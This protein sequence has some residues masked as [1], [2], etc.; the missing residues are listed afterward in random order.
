MKKNLLV[1]FGEYRTF[2]Y[3]IPQLDRLNEVDIIFSTWD[4]TQIISRSSFNSPL[5]IPNE[6]YNIK[7]HITE[8]DIKSI[9]SNCNPIIHKTKSSFYNE[10]RNLYKMHFHWIESLNAI[11]DNSKYDKLILHRS[12]MVSDWHTL[13]DRNFE[14][15]TIYIDTNRAQSN[16]ENY[17]N[18]NF[19][20]GDYSFAGNYDVM[21]KFINLFKNSKYITPQQ[22]EPHYYL[23]KA[24]LEN[25][26]KWNYLNL[27]TFLVRYNHVELFNNLNKSN[28][29]FL[30]L[31]KGCDEWRYYY[32]LIGAPHVS[33]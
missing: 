15:D 2:E 5:N 18:D 31:K 13:L 4:Y 24:I 11:N 22:T 30:N 20:V 25:N 32:E 8:Y 29:K 10:V 33:Y 19:W 12:D 6:I 14:K 17:S 26:F 16:S 7:S 1:F 9:L 3:I 23:G 28:I 27:N 21:T